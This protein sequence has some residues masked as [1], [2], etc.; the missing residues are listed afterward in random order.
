MMMRS[1]VFAALISAVMPAPGHAQM[2]TQ[3]PAPPSG[4]FQGTPDEQRACQ[5]DATRFCRAAIP[6][7]FRVLACLQANREK[8]SKP[9]RMVL[10]SHGQ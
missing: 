9:C 6:D 3:A 10:E 2:A 1:L 8:I 7:T 4:P 5:V